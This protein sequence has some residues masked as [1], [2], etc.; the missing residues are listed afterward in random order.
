[1]N[2]LRACLLAAAFVPTLANAAEGVRVCLNWA[3]GAD[4]APLYFAREQGW[5]ADANV[6]VEV[7]PGGGSGEALKKLADGE[8]QAAIADFGAVRAAHASGRDVVA[9]MTI[10]ADSPLAFY[11]LDT[12]AITAP[13]DLAGQ[14]IAAY[15]TDPPR[16]L[17]P[18]FAARHGLA[19]N[20]V[21]WIDLPN[22]AKVAALGRGEVE[23]AA[24]GFYH[25]HLEYVEAFGE[26]LRILWWRD[27][28]PNPVGQVLALSRT[29][30]AA[31]PDAARAFVRAV[32]RAHAA[33]V[34][35]GLPCVT[36]LVDANPHLSLAREQARWS[37]ARPLIAPA[38]RAGLTL[39]AFDPAQ[40]GA[41]TIDQGRREPVEPPYTDRLLDPAVTSPR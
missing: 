22:N 39:G 28:G 40:V 9:V 36:A 19:E 11:S 20:A 41:D 18:A 24:N 5:F 37:A 3:P 26:R 17:W 25:H 6:A 21:T 38:R 31:H 34:R 35:D 15:A 23:V 33:C 32:Q 13:G 2:R 16:R 1:M 7:L 29:W 4:H 27:L 12:T 30:I 8:C 10:F 14:R